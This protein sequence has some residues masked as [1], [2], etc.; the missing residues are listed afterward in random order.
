MLCDAGARV[1]IIRLEARAVAKQKQK[2][3]K[4]REINGIRE[5]FTNIQVVFSH[6]LRVGVGAM[7]AGA[8]DG[9]T[10]DIRHPSRGLPSN[11]RITAS[12]MKNK[13]LCMPSSTNTYFSHACRMPLW[14]ARYAQTT[15]KM[16]VHRQKSERNFE[17]NLFCFCKH[18]KKK[19]VQNGYLLCS[20]DMMCF[21]AQSGA[22][23]G[24]NR[25]K[26]ENCTLG[27]VQRTRKGHG[28]QVC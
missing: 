15:A 26:R 2:K 28:H 22:T 12:P 4:T 5:S 14:Y 10:S 16:K 6:T 8:D 7:T 23:M 13:K 11:H 19:P 24:K 21:H 3:K 17:E 27:Y 1:P 18:T 9:V 20:H 25:L